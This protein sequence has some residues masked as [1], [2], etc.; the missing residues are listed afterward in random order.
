MS[1]ATIIPPK[2]TLRDMEL[3]DWFAG[4]ALTGVLEGL[5][6]Q[7]DSPEQAAKLVADMSYIIADAML[8]A[9]K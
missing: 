8:E 4:Q 5:E 7:A 6:G 2:E 3:R 9:R 1:G